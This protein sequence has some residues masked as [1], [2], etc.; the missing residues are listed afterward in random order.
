[1]KP[2]LKA[3]TDMTESL[4]NVMYFLKFEVSTAACRLMGCLI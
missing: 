3:V 1:M 4:L 2:V